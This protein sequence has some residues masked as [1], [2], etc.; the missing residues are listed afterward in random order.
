MT[1]QAEKRPQTLRFTMAVN[2]PPGRDV[3]DAPFLLPW[4][5]RATIGGPGPWNVQYSGRWEER[6]CFLRFL[7]VGFY[8]IP[9]NHTVRGHAVR[10]LKRIGADASDGQRRDG[11]RW[12]TY[13][14]YCYR[15]M[16]L[17]HYYYDYYTLLRSSSSFIRRTV[18]RHVTC[19]IPFS[20]LR[21]S[22]YTA[23]RYFIFLFL[24]F[25]NLARRRPSHQVVVLRTVILTSKRHF[26]YSTRTKVKSNS[27]VSQ[28]ITI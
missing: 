9:R 25:G 4:S 1:Y 6:L 7:Q 14:H 22:C 3:D 28:H 12:Q 13:N 19:T 16:L 27:F 26:S 2:R 23:K 17:H 18:Y 24:Y 15:T 11:Q 10:I 5:L 8:N 21:A 20:R